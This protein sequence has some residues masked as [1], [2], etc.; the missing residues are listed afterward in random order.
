MSI[1]FKKELAEGPHEVYLIPDTSQGPV[2]LSSSVGC[3]HT[4]KGRVGFAAYSYVSKVRF[5]LNIVSVKFLNY[6][7]KCLSLYS[8]PIQIQ[9]R[10]QVS[11]PL[12][13][14]Y[15]KNITR[16]VWQDF[17]IL[18]TFIVISFSFSALSTKSLI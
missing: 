3:R 6:H 11:L 14:S 10:L 9:V 5:F 15:S 17:L 12:S 8:T 7:L 2:H 4:Y 13:L 1:K 16:L 18:I